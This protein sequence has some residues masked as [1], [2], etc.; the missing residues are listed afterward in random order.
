M[1]DDASLSSKVEKFVTV[2]VGIKC[3]VY[4]W[5]VLCAL[6]YGFVEIRG[7]S[8]EETM[9]FCVIAV[10]V[11]FSSYKCVDD[12]SERT[13]WSVLLVVIVDKEDAIRAFAVFEWE[14]DWEVNVSTGACFKILM[15][16][17]AFTAAKEVFSTNGTTYREVV[18]L[19]DLSFAPGSIVELLI[20]AKTFLE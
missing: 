1:A 7:I 5:V 17:D 18:M 12:A 11:G 16:T 8:A 9:T 4:V 6:E 14:D 19:S 20:P 13:D 2:F 10:E 15:K 3:E